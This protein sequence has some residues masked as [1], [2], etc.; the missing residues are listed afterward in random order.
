MSEREEYI[1]KEVEKRVQDSLK[2]FIDSCTGFPP[3][4]ADPPTVDDFQALFANLNKGTTEE[5]RVLAAVI[6][7]KGY[8]DKT[9]VTAAELR[10]IGFP[11]AKDIPDVAW[12]PRCAIQ[13]DVGD[14]KRGADPGT[15][16]IDHTIS[17]L[18]PF[19]FVQVSFTLQA[20]QT[21]E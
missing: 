17:F 18:V 5:R 10:A 13:F 8:D 11:L 14:V 12:V 3:V 16:M 1:A 21:H 6:A 2:K 20:A 19:Q 7:S 15:V 9:C 4:V